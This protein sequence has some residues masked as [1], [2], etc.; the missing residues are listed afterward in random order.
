MTNPPADLFGEVATPTHDEWPLA[1]GL[2][3]G[4]REASLRN[5]ALCQTHHVHDWSRKEKGTPASRG[6]STVFLIKQLTACLQSL[7]FLRPHGGSPVWY[8]TGPV[9]VT[10]YG[11]FIFLAIEDSGLDRR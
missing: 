3:L 9:D 2:P 8:G 1:G 11:A 6:L 10:A 5:S 7:I 4:N